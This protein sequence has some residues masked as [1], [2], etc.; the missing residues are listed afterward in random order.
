M[1]ANEMPDKV[2][3]HKSPF[4]GLMANYKKKKKNG[5]EYIKK[6]IFIE[7]A[8]NYLR[9]NCQRFKKKKKDI[10]DFKNYMKEEK[11]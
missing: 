1:K 3:I 7:K 9:N 8:D 6:D 10:E 4:W 2:Y 11:L 5:I